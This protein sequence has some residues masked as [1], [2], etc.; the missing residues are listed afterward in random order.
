[1]LH[2]RFTI[3][4]LVV[5]L[6]GCANF[7]SIGRST[8]LGVIG[9]QKNTAVHL[10]GQQRVILS[11][12]DMAK[13]CA[14]PSPD[15]MAAYAASLGL[16]VNIP[17]QGG[18]SLAQGGQSSAANIGLRTQS[19]TLM[20]DAL[21]R[22]CEAAMN[23]MIEP[24]QNATMLGRGMDLTAVVLAVEQLTGA[25]TASQVALTGST[26]ASADSSSTKML[27]ANAQALKIAED[28]RDVRKE[29]L[30]TLRESLEGKEGDGVGGVN[31]KI[32]SKEK[33]VL[34]QEGVLSNAS[35]TDEQ[36][37]AATKLRNDANIELGNL[38]KEKLRLQNEIKLK[39]K[40]V[41][42]AETLVADITE[43]R[44][45]QLLNMST[46]A[47]SET[48]G[49]SKFDKKTVKSLHENN[50]ANIA[51]VAISVKEMV[52]QA[53]DKDYSAEACLAFLS[54]KLKV[55]DN[56][57]D[58]KQKCFELIEAKIKNQHNIELR[59]IVL[60][61]LKLQKELRALDIEKLKLQQKPKTSEGSTGN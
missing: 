34:T 57:R 43:T 60:N 8:S 42:S 22:I 20:R 39:E 52:S 23:G 25:V 61:E 21:Y 11:K 53:L 13:V 48:G 51:Q 7:N 4:L 26:K 6:S 58:T 5:I 12:K 37:Q 47:T 54:S 2:I 29:E 18:G 28:D 44:E 41:K 38:G 17:T 16:G 1:M 45:G 59:K 10:D 15:V 19:I 14:E 24:V 55:I 30:K 33:I 50:S 56:I 46:G 3:F 9:N 32:T 40:D 36:K 49:E 31:G 27:R 35:S